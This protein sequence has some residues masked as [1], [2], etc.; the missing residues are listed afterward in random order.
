MT[1]YTPTKVELLEEWF[2][3][4]Q[5]FSL[6]DLALLIAQAASI[7]ENLEHKRIIRQLENVATNFIKWGN[8]YWDGYVRAIEDI[9]IENWPF[10]D[11]D[12][13]L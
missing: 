5:P 1:D 2:K 8:E 4:D 9:R 7:G 3:K 13:L 6:D 11:T 12:E 10:E